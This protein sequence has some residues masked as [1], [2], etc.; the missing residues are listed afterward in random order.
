MVLQPLPAGVRVTLSLIAKPFLAHMLG[1]P[2]ELTP[3]VESLAPF[4]RRVK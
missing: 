3:L 1:M 4:Y 2:L